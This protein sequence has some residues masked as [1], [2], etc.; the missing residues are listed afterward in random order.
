MLEALL[1]ISIVF[2]GWNWWV[3]ENAQDEIERLESEIEQYRENNQQL[4]E[5]NRSNDSILTNLEQAGVECNERY[6]KLLEEINSFSEANAAADD[7]IQ[8]LQNSL[9]GTDFAE[10]RVPDGIS[11]EGLKTTRD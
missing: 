3:K 7:Q 1:A 10:C 9:A 6:L 2:G 5:V 4:I 11:L 8:D